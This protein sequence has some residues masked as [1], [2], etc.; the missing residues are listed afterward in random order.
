MNS[1]FFK[2]TKEEKENIL[3]AHK[4]I[5]DGF[6]T[7]YG[8]NTNKTP[9]YV[10]DLANDKNGITVSN[11]GEVKTHTNV[12]INEDFDGRDKIADGPHDLKNGTVDFRGTPDTSDVNRKYFHDDYPSPNENENEYISV[13]FFD[14]MDGDGEDDILDKLDVD[15]DFKDR[16]MYSP[17]Y[18]DENTEDVIDIED[19]YNIFLELEEEDRDEVTKKVN[20]SLDMF[21]RFKK[22]Y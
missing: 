22:Y 12:K 11:K 14:D 16:S 18:D 13:G 20:E 1:Y 5:Y 8:K 6:V 9:L 15:D 3:D 17:Y 7:E 21:S 10:Q 4:S 2:M 19:D